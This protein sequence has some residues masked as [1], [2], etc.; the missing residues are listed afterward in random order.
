MSKLCVIATI[1]GTLAEREELNQC[2]LL[3]EVSLNQ[4]V[5]E[6][7]GLSPHPHCQMADPLQRTLDG[8]EASEAF[9]PCVLVTQ[10]G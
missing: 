6:R 1:R 2:A 8:F 9:L 4:L 10:E 7:L 5:R 3:N